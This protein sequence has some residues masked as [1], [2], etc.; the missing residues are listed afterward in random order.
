[1]AC[2]ELIVPWK[3]P[4]AKKNSAE[5]ALIFLP[6]AGFVS[7][8]LQSGAAVQ[9]LAPPMARAGSVGRLAVSLLE[10]NCKELLRACTT[11]TGW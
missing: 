10:S 8:F 6:P 5:K 4:T 9:I 1:M 11:C 7:L 2:Q 3:N